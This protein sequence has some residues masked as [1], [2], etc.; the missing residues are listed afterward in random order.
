LDVG[1][2]L[3]SSNADGDFK[4]LLKGGKSAEAAGVDKVED[5]PEFNEV[6]LDGCTGE[7]NAVG[8]LGIC[9]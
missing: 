8:S 4:L 2:V 9:Q 5:R 1:G 7:D 3:V 6:V